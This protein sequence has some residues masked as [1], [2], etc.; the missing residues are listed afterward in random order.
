M[1]IR[2]RIRQL[3]GMRGL[4]AKPDGSIIET[5]ITANFRE[6]L[7]VLQY[8]ISTHGARKG[9][10]DTAL[11]TAN[12]GYLTRRLVDVCQDLV[13]TDADCGTDKGFLREAI[14]QGGEIVIPLRDRV[15]GRV[16]AKDLFSP[17]DD[18]LLLAAGDM[19]DEEAIEL[20][21]AHNI[22]QIK[23]RSPIT[24]ETRYGVCGKCYGRDLGRGHIVNRGEAV[25]VIAAQ[26]I[27]EPGTQL[28]MRTFHIGGAATAQAAASNIEVKNSGT[29]TF[30]RLRVV[31]RS[32]GRNVVVSRSGELVVKDNHGVDRDCLLYTSP[33]PRDGLLYRNPSSA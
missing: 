4:M 3:A 12:S 1:C 9:L 2:D 19:I 10:A 18:A 24:C 29:V 31:K 26:S 21:E 17:V 16:L 8:F 14:V 20:I 23:A 30:N 28:T 27:G 5:P 25:G 15:L 32:D 13:V 6:G 7:N 33:S 22:N 11:K